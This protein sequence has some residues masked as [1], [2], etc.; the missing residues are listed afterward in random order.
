MSAYG[1]PRGAPEWLFPAGAGRGSG[2][3][4]RALGDY[5]DKIFRYSGL[6]R[7]GRHGTSGRCTAKRAWHEGCR[8]FSERRY[9][10]HRV[11]R[12]QQSDGFV[13]PGT[14]ELSRSA[15]KA[16]PVR[17]RR[18]AL[19]LRCSHPGSGCI[20]SGTASGWRAGRAIRSGYASRCACSTRTETA[21]GFWIVVLKRLL[22]SSWFHWNPIGGNADIR[23][24]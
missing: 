9:A 10:R 3:Y 15:A 21:T 24:R 23:T 19:V 2:H 22:V 12:R 4:L 18:R 6:C 8:T 14:E 11:P 7:T 20:R 13:G 1:Q 17:H 16:G 5:R